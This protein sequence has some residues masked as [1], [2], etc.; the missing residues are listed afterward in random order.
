[1]V[2]AA[3]EKLKASIWK[4]RADIG[5]SPDPHNWSTSAR[6]EIS[7]EANEKTCQAMQP[8]SPCIRSISK[9]VL[10]KSLG[11]T[12]SHDRRWSIDKPYRSYR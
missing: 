12:E 9:C 4:G 5:P 2:H 1:M 11:V 6:L 7:R 3:Y 10:C 8:I